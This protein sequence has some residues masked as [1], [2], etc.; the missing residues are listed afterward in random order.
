[1]VLSYIVAA[2]ILGP[3]GD[4]FQHVLPFHDPADSARRVF[5]FARDYLR[6]TRAVRQTNDMICLI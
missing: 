3:D 6:Y 4:G 1:V 2:G 5:N